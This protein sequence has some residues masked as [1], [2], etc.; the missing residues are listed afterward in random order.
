MT[1]LTPPM[2]NSTRAMGALTAP[3]ITA[4]A[5]ALREEQ[6]LLQDLIAII[7]HQREAVSR[8]DLQALDDSV[9]GTHRVLLTLGEARRRRIALNQRLGESDD[10]SIQALLDAFGGAPP[11]ELEAAIE[12]LARTGERLHREVML[13][14]RVLRI[15]VEAGDQLVRALCGN[16]R[17]LLDRR[18]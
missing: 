3:T 9:F 4:L 7:L 10:L 1:A 6:A 8:D 12:S 17:G 13:N 5:A 14:Q 18:A 16:D 11:A 2:G 15:A